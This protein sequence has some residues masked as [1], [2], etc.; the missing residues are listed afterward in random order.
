MIWTGPLSPHH[1]LAGLGRYGNTATK[2]H[3]NF[4]NFPKIAEKLRIDS[5]IV[6]WYQIALR[7]IVIE[8]NAQGRIFP[9]LCWYDHH[10]PSSEDI[11]SAAL[12]CNLRLVDGL[13]AGEG[14]ADEVV[15]LIMSID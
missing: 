6:I 3:R 13:T 10:R 5:R 2:D 4:C 14:T 12:H 15:D 9:P 7:R 1:W 8:R 11:S